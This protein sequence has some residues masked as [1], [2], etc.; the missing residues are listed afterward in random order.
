MALVR[1]LLAEET[2]FWRDLVSS[3]LRQDCSFE[4]IAAVSDGLRAVQLAER[5][6]PA[7]VLLD[8]ELPKLSGIHAGGWIRMLAPNAKIVFLAERWEA[9]VVEAAMRFGPGGCVL[10]PRAARDLIAAI[11]AVGR[12][13]TFF[14]LPFAALSRVHP[15]SAS[16][17]ARAW[18]AAPVHGSSLPDAGLER[19]C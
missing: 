18:P 2:R 3:V 8:V 11:Q 9:A 7:V 16:E 4:V 19:A 14:R 17:Q 15:R 10:K 6:Q 13:E 12:G 5:L 1:I